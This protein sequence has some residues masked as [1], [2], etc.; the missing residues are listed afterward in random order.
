MN[1]KSDE[2]YV[3]T[4]CNVLYVDSRFNK[5]PVGTISVYNGAGQQWFQACGICKGTGW[6]DKKTAKRY[7]KV[8]PYKGWLKNA[9]TG[10]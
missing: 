4:F 7:G 1:Q 6:V 2:K 10:R 8:I 9:K 5:R 3:C